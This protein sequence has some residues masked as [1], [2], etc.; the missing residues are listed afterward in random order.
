MLYCLILLMATL[1]HPSHCLL[2]IFLHM[3]LALPV[4]LPF[5]PVFVVCHKHLKRGGRKGTPQ[6]VCPAWPSLWQECDS[7][8]QLLLA[9]PH[10][11]PIPA[12][13]A[14]ALLRLPNLR[15]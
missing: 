1:F 2:L 6:C 10:F 5:R 3:L 13:H 11:P 15:G 4:L 9:A 7:N 8:I 14:P 12:L